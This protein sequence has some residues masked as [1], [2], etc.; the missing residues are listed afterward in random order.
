MGASDSRLSKIIFSN[1]P[2]LLSFLELDREEILD[3]KD[4]IISEL[5]GSVAQLMDDVL[6]GDVELVPA[7][8]DDQLALLARG[9]VRKK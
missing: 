2:L 1:F 5:S 6:K 8:P 3:P 9:A 4:H 7:T